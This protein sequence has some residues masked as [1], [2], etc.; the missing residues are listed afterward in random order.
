MLEFS[1][2]GVRLRF[3]FLFFA[4]VT[5][6]LIIDRSGVAIT[7]LICCV[8]HEAGHIAAFA[9]LNRKPGEVTFDAF[10][11]KLISPAGIMR[12]KDEIF[13]LSAGCAVNFF[14]RARFMPSALKIIFLYQ[15]S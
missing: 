3:S 14:L 10:G 8:L 9:A 2:F 5:A 12:F 4:V 1:L 11:I 6:T 13:V 7:G 15:I